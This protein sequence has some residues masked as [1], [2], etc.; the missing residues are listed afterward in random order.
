MFTKR[1]RFALAAAAPAVALGAGASDT[2]AQSWNEFVIRTV[3]GAVTPVVPVESPS[4]FGI[5]VNIDESGEKAGYGTGFFDGQAVSS[6]P[7]VSYTRVDPGLPD[8]YVNIWVTDGTNYAVIAP[9]TN[10]MS[11]GGYTSNDVNGLD[12][13]TLGFNV[14]E[15]N[16]TNLSWM[17][18]GATRVAQGLMK[19]DG[20]PVLVSEI[21]G[22]LVD[23]PGIYSGFVGTG[24]PKNDTGFNLIFGDTQ[25]NFVSPVPYVLEN[26]A[27]PEPTGLAVVGLGGAALLA[28][29]RRHSA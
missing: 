24:A 1:I 3:P 16:L 13:Q 25:G 8:P 23:D 2:S 12:I 9:V 6:I 22:L 15:T 28:R 10:M 7:G 19:S 11:G 27:V 5:T 18:P 20:T 17:Y 29:R 21:G 26:V 14:Y 4:G